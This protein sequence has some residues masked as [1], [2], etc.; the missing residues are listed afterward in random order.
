MTIWLGGPT[1]EALN[2][3]SKN[4][5]AE[6]LG[7]EFIE[8][9]ED[10]LKARMPVDARTVQPLRIL[11]GGASCA[12][13]ETAASTAANICVDQ[14]KEYCI[15]LDINANHLR[16]ITE[17]SQVIALIRPLHVGRKTQV[18]SAEL[19]NEKGQLTCVGRMTMMVMQRN[20]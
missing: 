15:G 16:S 8:L 18:W 20:A 14:T 13:I 11:N 12:L 9:G 19:S 17:P 10:Y 1:L 7:I 2:Q 5:L 6:Y 4:T 3:R